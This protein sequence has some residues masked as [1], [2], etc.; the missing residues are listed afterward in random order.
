[1][2]DRVERLSAVA[3]V[4]GDPDLQIVWRR[5]RVGAEPV[6][7]VALLGRDGRHL[8]GSVSR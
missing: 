8:R 3:H 6:A 5:N 2:P 1:M 4:Q 7:N